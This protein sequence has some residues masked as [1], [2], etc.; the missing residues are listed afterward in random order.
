MTDDRAKMV[1]IRDLTPW[2]KNPRKNDP[3]VDAVADSIR[4][5]GFASP[6]LARL[7]D[8]RVIA[9]HTR[10]KA[11]IKLGM[12]AV[13]VRYLDLDDDAANALALADNKLGELA[14][15]DDAALAEILSGLGDDAKGLGWSDDEI[16][17]MLADS[18][19]APEPEDDA[20]EVREEAVS[21]LG[22][23]YQ[24]GPHR[25]ACGSSSDPE[26]WARLLGSE[27][28]QMVWTDPPYGVSIVGG[29]KDPRNPA[30]QSGKSIENDDLASA[31]LREF[32][33]DTLGLT[34]AH[35]VAGSSWYVAA[36]QG[37]LF[38][39]FSI[40]LGREFLDIHRHTLVWVKSAFVF[41]RSDYHY[42][43]EP[44]FYGWVPGAGHYFVDDR[45]QAS[46]LEFPRPGPSDK[47]HPT[48]KPLDLVRRCIRNSSR[49]GWLIG[50]PFCGSGTTL[51][52]AAAESRICRA[53]ELDPRYCDVIR[54]R[55]GKYARENNLE[56]GDGLE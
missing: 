14:E 20:P 9:G 45:T 48:M 43:H 23:V 4:R 33:T 15:W 1:L 6:I 12:E 27:R 26:V 49:P 8:G 2:A 13:P 16:A 22:E 31:E 7:A 42:K 37:P 39:E 17:A 3:A 44:I 40:V 38:T 47:A 24:L 30:Y 50:E 41:G 53:I 25:L 56:V 32:L 36:P 54:R 35:C 5:F 28:L 18:E 11:A 51:L 21:V 29:N 10:L 55:W 19:P 52:A 46:V 34:A